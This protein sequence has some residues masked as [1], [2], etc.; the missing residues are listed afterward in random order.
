MTVLYVSRTAAVVRHEGGMLTVWA[1]EPLDEADEGGPRRRRKLASIEPHRLESVILLGGASITAS[2]MRAC[3]A[4][5]LPVALLDHGG[6]L[7]ARVV[8]PESRTADLRI[9]Q[10]RAWLDIA[11]RLVRARA[12]VAAKLTNAARVLRGVRSN[13]PSPE[14]AA[15]MRALMKSARTAAGASD[16]QVLLGVEGNG[17]REYFAGLAT[18]FRADITFTG[19]AQRPP[20]D[21]A[22]ALLSFGYVLL[23]NR[24]SGLLEAR[25][26]DP[27][28]GFY[29]ELRPGRPSLA[30][31]LLEELRH[32]VVDR[33]VLRLANLR[34]LTPA[35]FEPDRDRAGGVR[36]SVDAR[37]VFLEEWEQHLSRPLRE[38]GVE[39]DA[40]L[41]VHRL[42]RRQVDRVVDDLRGGETYRPFRF[43]G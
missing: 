1:E 2:A 25:G 7:A 4:S 12:V 18:A 41:N 9:A 39:P 27:C 22:N 3:A 35:D 33:F 15:A 24:I 20:P 19:R 40:R 34:Q 26:V 6:N 42:I 31:D 29:H 5:R 30:L 13:Y 36:L 21:P 32:P 10:Y 38:V 23:S 17:A 28:I 11:E 37:R 8:P 43:A 16:A 14:L